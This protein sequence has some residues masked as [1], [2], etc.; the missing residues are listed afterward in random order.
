MKKE[1]KKILYVEDEPD[2]R[3]MVQIALVDVAGFELKS[4]SS[5]YEAIAEIESFKPDLILLDVMMPGLDGP[6]TLVELRKIPFVNNIP[7]L[8]ITAGIQENEFDKYKTWGVYDIISKPFE[9]LALAGVLRRVWSKY[10]E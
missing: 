10:Y 3:L 7:T 9:P 4:C 8:F 6:A 1:L 2:I 5:G